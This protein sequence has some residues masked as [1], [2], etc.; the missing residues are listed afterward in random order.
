MSI[1]EIQRRVVRSFTD[2]QTAVND[3]VDVV[4][5]LSAVPFMRG[6]MVD[7]DFSDA[8]PQRV[9][10]GIDRK[11]RGFMVASIDTAATVNVD[12]TQDGRSDLYIWLNCSSGTAVAKV[13]V[14]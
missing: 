8:N 6:R 13:W 10:T 7:V 3:L 9:R 4:R 2:A 14:Y 1:R 12:T 11:W 5:E